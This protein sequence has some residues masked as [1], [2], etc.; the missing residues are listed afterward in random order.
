M[1][2]GEKGMGTDSSKIKVDE[3][4]FHDKNHN[5]GREMSGNSHESHEMSKDKSCR[6]Y[7]ARRSCGRS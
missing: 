5:F 6:R 4:S 3:P 2:A 1:Q 7:A